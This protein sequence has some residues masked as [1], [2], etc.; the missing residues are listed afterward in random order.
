[1]QSVDCFVEICSVRDYLSIPNHDGPACMT[2]HLLIMGYEDDGNAVVG[3]QLSKQFQD[4]STRARVEVAGRFV[5]QENWWLIGQ[6]PRD[7]HSL[8]LASRELGGKMIHAFSQADTFQEMPCPIVSFPAA[9]TRRIEERQLDVLQGTGSRQEIETLEHKTDL[10]IAQ[11]GS[12]V[13]RHG[14][15]LFA[16]EQLA[17]VGGAVETTEGVHEC[18]LAGA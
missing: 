12:L 15:D 3:I 18:G 10:S 9:K 11:T 14:Y 17:A 8:L 4:L 2:G 13:T 6:S 16:V 5:G 1:V 7:G